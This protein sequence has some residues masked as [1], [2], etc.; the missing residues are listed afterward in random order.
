MSGRAASRVTFCAGFA[1]FSL[2]AA[3]AQEAVTEPITISADRL[4]DVSAGG[5]F[6]IRSLDGE[7]LRHS[8]QLR[9][10]NI[11]R[12]QVPGFSPVAI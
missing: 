10:D 5:P 6:A 12:A 7:T 2:S 1:I 8:P 11:L 4:P 3:S 9:L